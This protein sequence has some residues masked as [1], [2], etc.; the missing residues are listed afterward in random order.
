MLVFT[1]IES[2]TTAAA[3]APR[4]MVLVQETHDRIM[5]QGIQRFAGY[6]IH[7][8]GDAFEIAFATAVSATQFCL[9]TQ[10]QLM[11]YDWPREVLAVPQFAA[12][13]D[14]ETDDVIFRGPRVRMGVHAAPPGTWRKATHGYTHHTVFGGEGVDLIAAVSDAGHGC[15]LYTSPSPRD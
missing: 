12:V 6:E 5:R 1:D 2:S 10:D 4:A 7:T 9:W 8:Q 3:D 14:E 13:V 15:L 11:S